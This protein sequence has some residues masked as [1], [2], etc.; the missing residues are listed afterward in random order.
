MKNW[1]EM[2]LLPVAWGEVFD[3][4]T[5]LRIK[6]SKLSDP[7]KLANVAKE[8]VAIENVVGAMDRFPVE[9]GL[10]IDQLEEINAELWVVEDSKRACERSQSFGAEFIQ[11]ARKVYIW[12]DRRAA[13]KRSINELL[14]SAIIEEKGYQSYQ[15]KD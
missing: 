1:S 7:A 10:L 8:R 3:K 4:L 11:L 9:L 12:N 2:P 15:V 14:G 13:V 6:S 5:I